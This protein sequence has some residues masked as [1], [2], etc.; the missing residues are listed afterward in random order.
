MNLAWEFEDK[1]DAVEGMFQNGMRMDGVSCHRESYG[2]IMDFAKM[3][4]FL[5]SEIVNYTPEEWNSLISHFEHNAY[6]S[7]M[8]KLVAI[9]MTKIKG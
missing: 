8:N 9:Q 4:E 7:P 6:L 1:M 5:K 3:E 2:T